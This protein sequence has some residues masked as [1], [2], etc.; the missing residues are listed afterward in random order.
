MFCMKTALKVCGSACVWAQGP[1]SRRCCACRPLTPRGASFLHPAP[2]WCALPPARCVTMWLLPPFLPARCMQM[3][4]FSYVA[5]GHEEPAAQ[6]MDE[7]VGME[8][9]GAVRRREAEVGLEPAMSL[10]GLSH[11]KMLWEQLLDTKCL[12]C[13]GQGVVV[14]AFRG[15]ASMKNALADI[16]VIWEVETKKE[17]TCAPAVHRRPAV[18]IHQCARRSC[19]YQH[20]AGCQA[21]SN[22]SATGKACAGVAPDAP[23]AAGRLR[24]HDPAAGALWLPD[25]LA[26]Q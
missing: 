4:F 11:S 26:G 1:R 18:S 2:A 7:A 21:G 17:N 23:P 3:C 6:Q 16:K 10:Y 15:T 9:G 24:P 13:W 25:F 5:Y 22:P 12:V 19:A 8:S 20:R 14:V